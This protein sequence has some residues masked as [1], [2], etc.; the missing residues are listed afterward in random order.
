[1]SDEPKKQSRKWILWGPLA[2]IALYLLSSV[3]V[4][5]VV[6]WIAEAGLVSEKNGEAFVN[7]IYAPLIWIQAHSETASNVIQGI[8]KIVRPLAP[9]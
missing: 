5:I 4:V 9:P 7:T 8:G 2:A 1:M 6:A 3:P